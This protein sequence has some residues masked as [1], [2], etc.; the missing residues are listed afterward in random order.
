MVI[1]DYFARL[2][3]P[4]PMSG[5]EL[6]E[7]DVEFLLALPDREVRGSGLDDLTAYI[8]G[9]PA[10]GRKHVILRS[11]TDI[12][13]EMV[14]GLVTEGDGQGTG[15]FVSV[16][17]VSPG[18]RLARYQSFFHPVFGMFPLPAVRS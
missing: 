18:G 11:S 13:L 8:A 12:D 15:S 1:V 3:G 4:D 10:V 16:G 6:T 9:R 2:D 5:L 17:L 7:P 14:Y